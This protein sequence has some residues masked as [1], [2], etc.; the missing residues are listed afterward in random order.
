MVRINLVP[1]DR[2][3]SGRSRRKGAAPAQ[4]PATRA[5]G[6]WIP[7]SP[8][9]LVG[10]GCLV[11]TVGLVFLYF[12]ARR[13]RGEARAGMEEAE[14]DSA[15]LAEAV[16]RGRTMEAAQERLAAQ[17]AVME[18]VVEGRLFW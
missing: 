4:A 9:F 12:G 11:V 5:G 2:K 6:Q 10:G 8:A 1:G 16:E 14:A 3:P 15:R 18:D 13:A 17:V 7:E